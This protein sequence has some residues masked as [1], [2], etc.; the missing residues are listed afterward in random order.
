MEGA[1][2]VMH[3]ATAFAQYEEGASVRAVVQPGIRAR[4]RL[5]KRAAVAA[6]AI[7]RNRDRTAAATVVPVIVM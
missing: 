4:D 2:R 1:D 5:T 3:T 7:V 6:A